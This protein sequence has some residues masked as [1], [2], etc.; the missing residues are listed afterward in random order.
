MFKISRGKKNEICGFSIDMILRR[1][2]SD[3]DPARTEFPL[4]AS[5]FVLGPG[6]PDAKPSLHWRE[7]LL[8]VTWRGFVPLGLHCSR[9]SR[10]ELVRGFVWKCQV[11][12]AEARR[13]CAHRTV[14]A[15]FF[16]ATRS[17]PG[18]PRAR[19][20]AGGISG[21]VL[22]PVPGAAPPAPAS[23]PAEPR[24]PEVTELGAAARLGLTA[25]RQ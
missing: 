21:G 25:P 11:G 23:A 10:G 16:F 13:G 20:A 6:G 7:G 15:F 18:R 19:P 9:C 24:G 3:R 2:V 14:V 8:A 1:G 4:P 22:V 12:G 17:A 5:R